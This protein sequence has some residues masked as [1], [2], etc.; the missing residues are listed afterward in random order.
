MTFQPCA[1]FDRAVHGDCAGRDARARSPRLSAGDMILGA[2]I[3]AGVW[4]LISIAGFCL[5]VLRRFSDVLLTLV[6]LALAG[7]VTWK[8]CR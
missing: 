1:T 8:S 5:I 4:A 3:Q 6:P 7:V 2:F